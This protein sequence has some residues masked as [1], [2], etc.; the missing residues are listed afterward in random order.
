M[1]SIF[2]KNFF[3]QL[4]ICYRLVYCFV[5]CARMDG[6]SVGFKRQ[7]S[8]KFLLTLLFRLVNANNCHACMFVFLDKL[9]FYNSTSPRQPI[10]NLFHNWHNSNNKS[11]VIARARNCNVGLFFSNYVITMYFVKLHMYIIISGLLI[12]DCCSL[13]SMLLMSVC[14]LTFNWNMIYV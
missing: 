11:S 6:I 14:K 1:V 2:F 3:F 13:L 7:G 9:T 5:L 10:H 4:Q 8:L 12:V